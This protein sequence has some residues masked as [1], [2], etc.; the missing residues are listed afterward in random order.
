MIGVTAP[1]RQ[2]I[3]YSFQKNPCLTQAL[4]KQIFGPSSVVLCS[5][6]VQKLLD[7]SPRHHR[8]HDLLLP[9]VH[10]CSTVLHVRS[11]CQQQLSEVRKMR[12]FWNQFWIPILSLV[13]SNHENGY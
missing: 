8:N 3:E 9:K 5:L 13:S 1:G 11:F 2:E 4:D 7:H 10:L 6:K 12:T